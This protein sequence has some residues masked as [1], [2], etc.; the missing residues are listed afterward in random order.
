MH[1]AG[2]LIR[3]SLVYV[4]TNMVA[5]AFGLV[6]AMI[7]TRLLS[8]AS[9]GV[10]GL[11]TA[12]IMF[13]ATMFFDWHGMSFVRFSESHENRAEIMGTFFILFAALL[14]A[15]FII[16]GVIYELN[17]APAYNPVILVGLIGAWTAA[18]FQFT[19]RVQIADLQPVRAFWMNLTRASVT[20]AGSILIAYSTRDAI[21]VL[22]SN[23]IGQLIGANLF[24]LRGF[25]LSRISFNG[26]LARAVI[27][28]GYPVAIGMTLNAMNLVISRFMLDWLASID[29]VGR[30][31]AA[32]FFIQNTL[33]FIGSGIGTAS[34]PLAL[35]AIE[36]GDRPAAHRQLVHNF[37]LLISILVP[38]TIGLSLTVRN[39]APLLV[40]HD[41]VEAVIDLM[42]W[43]AAGAAISCIRGYYVDFSFQFGH[44]TGY[45]VSVLATV[46]V[47]NVGFNLL[48]IPRYGET[49]SAIAYVLALV[50]SLALALALSRRAYHVP[51]PVKAICKVAFAS[52]VMAGALVALSPLSGIAGLAAQIT[53]GGIVYGAVLVAV[54][55]MSIRRHLRRW[56]REAI[57]SIAGWPSHEWASQRRNDA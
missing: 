8:P 48:L 35:K 53:A 25:S 14:A 17:L 57:K 4:V 26:R 21:Y 9:Y 38:M 28:F 33:L 51:V 32:N 45:L 36:S 10:Y 24:G 16:F 56:F 12:L 40:G 34:Y 15:T 44:K 29:A 23:V 27:R 52:A 5:G 19:M 31:T 2:M 55:L 54:D 11:G 20:L 41:F 43:M 49:G 13:T 22:L 50:P 6:T 7:L 47:L 1:G 37:T 3:H 39:L 42:P 30:F 18:W 46:A